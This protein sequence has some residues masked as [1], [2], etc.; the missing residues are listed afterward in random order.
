M[1]ISPNRNFGHSLYR[2]SERLPVPALK[3]E[4]AASFYDWLTVP[5]CRSAGSEWHRTI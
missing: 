2:V 4:F 1:S 3:N 5:E